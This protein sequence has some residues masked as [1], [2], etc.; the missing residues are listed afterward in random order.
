MVGLFLLLNNCKITDKKYPTVK[1]K[2]IVI[3]NEPF[4]KFAIIDKNKKVYI[5]KYNKKF[6]NKLL[7]NQEKFVKLSYKNKEA[8]GKNT[9][10]IVTNIKI[11][12]NIKESNIYE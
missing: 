11:M 7:E 3:G 2:I 6:K 10:L 12:E 5:L 8:I 4:T 9:I 1:G